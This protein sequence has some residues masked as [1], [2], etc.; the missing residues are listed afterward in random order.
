MVT[1]IFT[2]LAAKFVFSAVVKLA[3]GEKDPT[4]KKFGNKKLPIDNC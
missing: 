3:S 2:L 1:A 4:Y